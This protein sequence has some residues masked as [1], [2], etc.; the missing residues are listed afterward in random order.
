MQKPELLA[1]AGS[2]E[3]LITAF[4]FGADACYLGGKDFSLR[5]FADN[6]DR[7][8]LLEAV[9]YAHSLGKKIYVT[10]NI[11]PSNRDFPALKDYVKYLGEIKAD[12]MLVTDPG[13]IELAK[14]VS[15][16]LPIHIST[17]A[18]VTNAYTAAF[19]HKMGA[20]RVVL[21]RELSLTEVK[22]IKDHCSDL[23]IECFVHGAMCISYSGRCL[24]SSYLTDRDSNR[25]ECVQACRWQY[26]MREVSRE[27]SLELQEDSRGAYVLNSYDMNMLSHLDDLIKA[28][29]DSFKIEGRMKTVYYVANV[30]NAYRR[31]LD[32]GDIVELDKELYKCKNRGYF[33][34]FYYGK[35]NAGVAYSK[36][37]S[38]DGY[39]FVAV[40]LEKKEDG[41]YLIEMRNRF[42]I[43]DE[44]EILSS[45]G[46]FNKTFK[47]K[48]IVTE[49]G[50]EIEDA[51]F[52]QQK[53]II[54]GEEERELL[55][56]DV[57]RRKDD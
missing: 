33:T 26:K 10:V 3:K 17:Q 36:E 8:G 6:F 22:E 7:E 47:V 56:L 14:T 34:G 32:G 35:E 44:L 18:N 54:Y 4:H 49:S 19:W 1:P 55:S 25:G 46:D 24:L 31:A 29:V 2:K 38:G 57:L 48:K 12:G 15:P 11:F 30:I 5:S 39:S 50:E 9:N 52:V 16:E 51:K 23:Q 41:G 45:G 40:V 37:Q 21:A 20:E 13:V 53:L 28:G 27:N 43:G 42:K